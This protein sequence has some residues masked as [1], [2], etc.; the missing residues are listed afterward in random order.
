MVAAAQQREW[1]MKRALSLSPSAG[2]LAGILLVLAALLASPTAMAQACK[3]DLNDGSC[4]NKGKACSPPAGGK[5]K[6][7]RALQE[8]TCNC[9]VP[10]PN[11]KDP[12]SDPPQSEPP[13]SET[14]EKNPDE[15]PQD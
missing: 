1:D 6:Q 7:G 13:Q 4:V 8:F 3:V 12:V 2:T 5:C 9:V 15:T 11:P 14:P 10:G